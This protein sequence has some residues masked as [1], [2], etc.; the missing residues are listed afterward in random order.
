MYFVY[1]LVDPRTDG[2]RYVGITNEPK[3]RFTQ[4]LSGTSQYNGYKIE[5]IQ[6]LKEQGLRP[7]MRIIETVD[8]K[9]EAKELERYWIEYY[10]NQDIQ[11]TN[12]EH[13]PTIRR[14]IPQSSGR[15][16]EF[17]NRLNGE[18]E[19]LIEANR[20]L[21]TRLLSK[22][23]DYYISD[24]D[25]RFPGKGDLVPLW[26]EKKQKEVQAILFDPDKYG[27]LPTYPGDTGA[28]IFVE[29]D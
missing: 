8:S 20:P 9:E 29:T 2:I 3:S 13:V 24:L 21:T 11:L 27:L 4:H 18:W 15:E 23:F 10:L 7:E 6:E 28:I 1:V 17:F 22:L 12:A 25:I 19:D 16:H 5:W 26:I 14:G